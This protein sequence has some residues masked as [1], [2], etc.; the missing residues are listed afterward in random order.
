M[1]N[2]RKRQYGSGAVVPPSKPGGTWGIRI[3]IGKQREYKGGIPTR[4]LAERTLAKWQADNASGE[5]GLPV[6]RD[7]G[8]TLGA[9]AVGFLARRSRT[10]VA[11]AEDASRW[12]KH[13]EPTFGHLRPSEVDRGVIRRFIEGRLALGLSPGT[14]RVMVALL[15]G[16]FEELVEDG[17]VDANPAKGLPKRILRLLAPTHDPKTTPFIE[18]L[19]DVQRIYADLPAPLSTAYAIGALAGLRTSEVFG[20]RWRSVDL[21]NRRIHVVEQRGAAK[22]P[23]AGRRKPKD[24]DSRIV[25]ILD[26]LLPV[27]QAWKLRC[28]GEGDT[29]VIPP[30]RK[31]GEFVKKSTSGRRLQATLKR[32]GLD[33]PGLGWY[34]ATRH[35]FASQWVMAGGSIEK[36]KEILGHYSV[37]MTERYAHLK[38]ELF[39]P[40][41]LGTIPLALGTGLGTLEALPGI[42]QGLASV[43]VTRGARA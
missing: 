14:V 34:E 15:S 17:V 26:G 28:G 33:R 3:R 38:P 1:K 9:Y 30:M 20:L 5:L 36:L 11:H 42:G 13:M 37:V 29:L 43:P 6:V 18:R 4:E 21:A 19:A 41:D 22:I 40:R 10:H 25:P 23:G 16:I 39:T 31:D 7:A 27:L 12:R 24:K 8:G 32:L 35:T 2:K